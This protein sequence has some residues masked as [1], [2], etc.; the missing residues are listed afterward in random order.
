MDILGDETHLHP[1]TCPNIFDQ[2]V[3]SR[4]QHVFL[5]TCGFPE[6]NA[7]FW[8]W[9]SCSAST[10]QRTHIPTTFTPPWPQ[11]LKVSELPWK[12]GG[13]NAPL[14][15]RFSPRLR[16]AEE[17]C[18]PFPQVGDDGMFVSLFLRNSS[19]KLGRIFPRDV[20]LQV[21]V[22]CMFLFHVFFLDGNN[23][24]FLQGYSCVM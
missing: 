14:S 3:Q 11:L 21:H 19:G 1:Q 10:H 18:H 6:G 2:Y 5:P 8:A 15:W 23:H 17:R 20:S 12:G 24:T 4:F 7:T 13:L 9:K 16:E 22:F